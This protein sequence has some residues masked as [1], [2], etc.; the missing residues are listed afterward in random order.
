[1]FTDHETVT[2]HAKPNYPQKE[3]LISSID[4]TMPIMPLPLLYT[5]E[6]S[7]DF[8][9][10]VDSLSAVLHY[11]Y[12][13]SGRFISKDNRA[14]LDCSNQGVFFTHSRV[15][16]CIRDKLDFAENEDL[17]KLSWTK[18]HTGLKMGSDV[19]PMIAR[20]IYTQD[21]CMVLF[22]SITH[23]IADAATYA[24]FV[25]DWGSLARGTGTPQ[26]LALKCP[27]QY[28]PS[29]SD[30][31]SESPD[32]SRIEIHPVPAYSSLEERDQNNEQIKLLFAR[33]PKVF[34]RRLSKEDLQHIKKNAQE[35]SSDGDGW[36]S[37][38]DALL[39][40]LWK[41]INT[42]RL[43]EATEGQKCDL[44]DIPDD[45]VSEGASDAKHCGD[46]TLPPREAYA[47]R[48]VILSQACNFRPRVVPEIE[49]NTV[50]NYVL[51]SS[52]CLS[53]SGLANMSTYDVAKKIRATISTV[54]DAGVRAVCND[55]KQAY[56]RE[57]LLFIEK[58]KFP[59]SY[60]RD[61]LSMTSWVGFPFHSADFKSGEAVW[62]GP[63]R[64][65]WIPGLI[66]IIPT[67]ESSSSQGIVR[68]V[69][70]CG[71]KEV[72]RGTVTAVDLYTHLV[73]REARKLQDRFDELVLGM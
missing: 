31:L 50:G 25:R 38:N 11:Y 15:E 65:D 22:L 8:P 3:I 61:D 27:P 70:D 21:N 5:Y 67:R 7:V 10:L 30:D 28:N 20:V 57:G 53:V 46:S 41:A 72:P 42:I 71:E 52:L 36:I 34:I 73:E 12:P 56:D 17:H 58:H 54:D 66:L 2:V 32:P 68:T 40:A 39:A 44:L 62:F 55:A 24:M 64:Q 60:V 16:T 4:A 69:D 43:E 26:E 63:P 1:M 49:E 47:K 19:P 23:W 35:D 59:Y 48:K 51:F 13:L 37:T 29:L 33:T 6:Y 14:V 18:D 9:V 45:R